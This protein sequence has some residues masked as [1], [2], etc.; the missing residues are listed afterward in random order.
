M[1]EIKY[2]SRKFTV[3]KDYYQKILARQ[4]I[5]AENVSPKIAIHSTLITTF[6][7]VRNEYSSA[8]TK[9]ITLEDLFNNY[10]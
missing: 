3:N 2:F 10:H 8:F 6:G 5:L 9:V 4:S 7:L 1:C